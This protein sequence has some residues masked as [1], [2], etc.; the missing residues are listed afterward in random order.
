MDTL[1]AGI[2]GGCVVVYGPS[3]KGKSIAVSHSL[4]GR[5]GV[6][7]VSLRTHNEVAEVQR[8]IAGALGLQTACPVCRT[9]FV[10]WLRG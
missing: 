7:H 9:I 4:S 2:K 3:G 8:S 5:K 1:E 10:D 6:M